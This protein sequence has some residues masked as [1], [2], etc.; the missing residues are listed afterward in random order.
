MVRAQLSHTAGAGRWSDYVSTGFTYRWDRLEPWEYSWFPANGLGTDQ[1]ALGATTKRINLD[2]PFS[3]YGDETS[4][5]DVSEDG[6]IHDEPLSPRS[7]VLSIRVVINTSKFW[8]R[9]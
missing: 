5:V 9:I 8:I 4:V 7:A 6:Y 3:F 2:T 1:G